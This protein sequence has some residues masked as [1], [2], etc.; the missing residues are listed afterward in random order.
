MQAIQFPPCRHRGE[1][2]APGL[3]RCHSAKLIGVKLVTPE[4]CQG[5]YCRDFGTAEV[6]AAGPAPEPPSP[7]PPAGGGTGGTGFTP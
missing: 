7:S 6:P 5:C 3:R 1:E 4:V 2:L